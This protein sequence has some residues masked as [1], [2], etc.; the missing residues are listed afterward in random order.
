MKLARMHRPST[1][2]INMTP[3]IDVVFLLIIFFMTVSQ[4]SRSLD[5]PLELPDVGAGGE[6]L[7]T[8]NITI[9]ID[10]RG[11]LIVTEKLL[12]MEQLVLAMTQELHRVGN[13]PGRLKVLIRC[14]RDCPGRFVNDLI[15]QLELLDIRHVRVSIKAINP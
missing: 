15:E 9:N 4:I 1:L 7:E 14:D 13:Q 6:S 2:G 8:V 11:Q 12:A 5:H 10:A 3:M